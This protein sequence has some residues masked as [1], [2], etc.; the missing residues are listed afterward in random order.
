MR[1]AD[2]EGPQMH[3]SQ[4]QAVNVMDSICPSFYH[5]LNLF[6]IHHAGLQENNIEM[7]ANH[8]IENFISTS[9]VILVQ[10]RKFMSEQECKALC[11]LQYFLHQMGGV[12]DFLIRERILLW[13][14]N[15]A[16]FVPG[17]GSVIH[18]IWNHSSALCQIA[19][20][21]VCWWCPQGL[22]T[23]AKVSWLLR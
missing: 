16:A 1:T 4:W 8:R 9:V 3:L 6:S 12:I 5:D 15:T 19:C 11:R 13:K 21:Q 20:Q 10:R 18:T 7:C 22:P 17:T 2:P 14:P 23:N